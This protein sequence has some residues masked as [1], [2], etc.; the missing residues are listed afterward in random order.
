MRTLG[1]LFRRGGN[2]SHVAV[3]A[4]TASIPVSFVGMRPLLVEV[5][6]TV[7]IIIVLLRLCR[8]LG[9][10]IDITEIVRALVAIVLSPT[11]FALAIWAIISLLRQA[12][13]NP[14][15]GQPSA[16]QKLTAP[17]NL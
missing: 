9:L 14:R 6:L 2:D 11:A 4:F 8:I 12:R 15:R 3:D 17:Y 13:I 7:C 16:G 10:L 1:I 5:A